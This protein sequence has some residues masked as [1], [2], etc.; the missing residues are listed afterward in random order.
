[1]IRIHGGIAR[2]LLKI[3][4]EGAFIIKTAPHDEYKC[5]NVPVLRIREVYPGSCPSRISDPVS[6]ILDLGS[7]TPDL[8]S[9]TPD[10]G[11][12]IPD[13]TT[14]TTTKGVGKNLFYL[15]C[16]HKLTKLLII[17]F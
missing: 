11:N 4:L 15:F 3:K 2:G 14:T 7:R 17:L 9:R 12:Q 13:P 6:R 1:V 8:G 10:L 16:S 5:C